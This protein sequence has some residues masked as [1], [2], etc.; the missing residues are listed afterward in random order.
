MHLNNEDREPSCRSRAA[1]TAHGM[2]LDV[3]EQYTACGRP[4]SRWSD[5]GFQD[6]RDDEAF[7]VWLYRC[8]QHNEP[9]P[10]ITEH[11]LSGMLRHDRLHALLDD[12]LRLFKAYGRDP[13]MEQPLLGMPLLTWRE[14]TLLA[15]LTPAPLILGA[16]CDELARRCFTGLLAHGVE[17][18]PP[19]EMTRC[20]RDQLELTI[21]RKLGGGWCASD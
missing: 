19:Q 14:E 4:R 12:L 8:W 2:R 17:L 13:A 16:H 10:Y 6:L 11:R 21:A 9:T 5:L 15:M 7:V 3:D 1:Q 20:G 18:R